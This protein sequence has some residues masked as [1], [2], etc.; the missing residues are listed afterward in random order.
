MANDHFVLPVLDALKTG[1]IAKSITQQQF[2][3][4]ASSHRCL[5]SNLYFRK[6]F[7]A[8]LPALYQRDTCHLL[9][10]HK[11]LH[12]PILQIDDLLPSCQSR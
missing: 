12:Q 6:A 1:T 9:V 8:R 3:F 7:Q 4:S 10:A 11:V 5:L 2:C